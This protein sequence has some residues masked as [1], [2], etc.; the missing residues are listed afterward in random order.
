[1]AKVEFYL[2]LDATYPFAHV[3]TDAV[4]RPGEAISIA[5]KTYYVTLV[6]WALDY[7]DTP[8]RVLRANVTLETR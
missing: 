4:P 5:K 7:P 8:D 3:K 1:M 2:G 6:T